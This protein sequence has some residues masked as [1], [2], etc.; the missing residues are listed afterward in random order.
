MCCNVSLPSADWFPAPQPLAPAHRQGA[1]RRSAGC[2]GR[3]CAAQPRLVCCG[4]CAC[5]CGYY[6]RAFLGS[7]CVAEHCC[8]R[9]CNIPC[10]CS[11]LAGRRPPAATEALE[12]NWPVCRL[13]SRLLLWLPPPWGGCSAQAFDFCGF[14][15]LLSPW[16][17]QP[18]IVCHSVPE[19]A[20]WQFF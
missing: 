14:C 2:R 19:C 11:E 17:I 7:P 12:R 6:W 18:H 13:L 3:H 8:T 5:A 10:A 16:L 20:W 1:L 4:S 15:S 9:S